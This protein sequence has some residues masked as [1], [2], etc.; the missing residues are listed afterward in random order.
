MKKVRLFNYHNNGN[1]S[2]VNV[3]FADGTEWHRTITSQEVQKLAHEGESY[4]PIL[5]DKYNEPQPKTERLKMYGRK[6]FF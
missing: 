2:K 6:V 1:D 4:L 5:L 3:Y